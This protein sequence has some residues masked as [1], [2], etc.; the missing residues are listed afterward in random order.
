[1][2][3]PTFDYVPDE[4]AGGLKVKPL[5]FRARMGDGYEQRTSAGIVKSEQS[6]QFAVKNTDYATIADM[7]TFLDGLGP[8]VRPFFWTK[9]GDVSPIL[10]IQDGDY[11]K[12]NEKP[13]SADLSVMFMKWNGAEE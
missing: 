12:S 13:N 1:M 3:A 5:I 4:G 9:P 8:G 6:Y 11:T 10:W 7:I 2:A